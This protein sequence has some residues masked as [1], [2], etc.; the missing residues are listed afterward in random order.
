MNPNI[1]DIIEIKIPLFLSMDIDILIAL[2]GKLKNNELL[3]DPTI[4]TQLCNKFNISYEGVKYKDGIGHKVKLVDTFADLAFYANLKNPEKRQK[5]YLTQLDML[6]IAIQTNDYILFKEL[7][8][9][10]SNGSQINYVNIF[11]NRFYILSTETGKYGNFEI[12]LYIITINDQEIKYIL[13]GLAEGNHNN[14]FDKIINIIPIFNYNWSLNKL[15]AN[16]LFLG[17][18]DGNNIDLFKEYY[19]GLA[20]YEFNFQYLS[21]KNRQ[22]I[23]DLILTNNN[24]KPMRNLNNY[25]KTQLFYGYLEGGFDL[26]AKN[27]Y[28]QIEDKYILDH[29][30]ILGAILASDNINCYYFANDLFQFTS[31]EMVNYF[32]IVNVN[33]KEKIEIDTLNQT[34]WFVITQLYPNIWETVFDMFLRSEYSFNALIKILKVYNPVINYDYYI[35][36]IENIKKNNTHQPI[37]QVFLKWLKDEKI[38]Q[39]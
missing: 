15:T 11:Q 12:I 1:F 25:E 36:K 4:L 13:R 23:L 10:F 27:I 22:E 26:N 19:N 16:I 39:K 21:K 6:K 29:F 5:L 8:K 38:K 20:E 3:D 18:V 35:N 30:T 31:E 7:L 33:R 2:Y 32:N 17:I 28:D 37:N 24:K 14:M 9:S 34:L